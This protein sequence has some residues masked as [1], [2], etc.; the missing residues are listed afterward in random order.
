MTTAALG[1]TAPWSS[2]AV[3][4]AVPFAVF[5]VLMALEPWLGRELGGTLDSRWLYGARSLLVAGLLVLL[6]RKFDELVGSRRLRRREI[7]MAVGAG[8]VVLFAWVLLDGGIFVLSKPAAGFEPLAAD[9]GVDW[10]LVLIRLAGSALVV[11]LMEELFWRSLVMRW[12]ENANFAAAEAASVGIR[13]LLF[14]SLAFGFEHNQWAAGLLAG[15]VYGWLYMRYRNL[16]AAVVAHTV[17]NAGL[18]LWVV[19][20]GAWYFW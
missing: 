2:P 18:G 16:W 6:W 9:G 14:S 20:T 10:P 11:P 1:R 19:A 17:T 8:L 3:A 4:R 12:L 7:L 13:A 5:I 15:L